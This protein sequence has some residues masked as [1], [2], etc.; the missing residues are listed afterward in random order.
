MISLTATSSTPF[1][2]L[3]LLHNNLPIRPIPFIATRISKDNEPQIYRYAVFLH[4]MSNS[5]ISPSARTV[6]PILLAISFSHLLNDSIHSLIPSTYPLFKRSLH[7]S[8]GQLGLITFC[9]Q[10]TA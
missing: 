4:P 9:F 7:L 10:L 5:S 8:F 1:I 3:N 6:F 2:P